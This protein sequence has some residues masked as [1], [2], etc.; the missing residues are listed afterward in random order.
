MYAMLCTRPDAYSVGLLHGLEHGRDL[1]SKKSTSGYLFTFVGGAISWQSKLQRCVALSTTEAEYIAITECCKELLW[2]KR[3]FEE[4][5][6]DQKRF[7]ILCDSQNAI[8]L[9]KN[10]SLHSKSKHIQVRYHWIR[11]VIEE[12]QVFI[13]KV[14]TCDNGANMMTKV[15]SKGKH[16]ACCAIDGLDIVP[17]SLSY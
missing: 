2:L 11:D 13:E 12:K 3:L 14:H 10:S 7:T 9:R 17:T 16:Y 4:I 5:G 1:D 8:H 6:I 15:L